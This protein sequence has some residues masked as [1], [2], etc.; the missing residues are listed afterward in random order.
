MISTN[1]KDFQ[2]EIF[3]QAIKNNLSKNVVLSPISVLFPL[4]I[5]SQGAK[6]KTLSEFQN[7][8]NDDYLQLLQ[9]HQ[10]EYISDSQ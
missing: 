6:G 1:L 7:M 3:K 10:Y 5:L 9:Y 8:L 4:S 2:L